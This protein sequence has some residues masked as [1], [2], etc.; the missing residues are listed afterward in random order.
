RDVLSEAFDHQSYTFDR[1]VDDLGIARDLS[2]SPLFDVM[3]AMDTAGG[4]TLSLAGLDVEPFP[5]DYRIS[6]FDLTVT[7]RDRGASGPLDVF[8]EFNTSLF[9]APTMR[10][11]ARR[12]E[13]LLRSVLDRPGD[14]IG[15]LPLLPADECRAVT[16]AWNWSSLDRPRGRSLP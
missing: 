9:S 4:E 14:P 15:R 2:R 13:A 6:K 12:L 1:L 8:F 5:I 3:V 10:R 16:D 7:F 11:F